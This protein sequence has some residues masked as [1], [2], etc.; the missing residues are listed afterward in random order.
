MQ[1]KKIL[2]YQKLK[3]L[4]ECRIFFF[5]LVINI[6][7]KMIDKNS[8]LKLEILKESQGYVDQIFSAISNPSQSVSGEAA[9]FWSMIEEWGLS[10]DPKIFKEENRGYLVSLIAMLINAER[11]VAKI[12]MMT[13]SR[14]SRKGSKWETVISKFSK[15]KIMSKEEK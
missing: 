15:T 9:R 7:G 12:F 3:R 11:D 5:G 1:E 10:R 14:P 6:G 4:L 8:D 2:Y 13:I